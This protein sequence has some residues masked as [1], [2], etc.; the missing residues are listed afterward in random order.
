MNMKFLSRPILVAIATITGSLLVAQT[1]TGSISG[2]VA[3]STG[4]QVA[5]ATVRLINANTR[6]TKT[7]ATTASGAYIF[8]IVAAGEYVM[9][10]ESAGFKLEKRGGVTINVNQNA[11]IDFVLQVGS[12]KETVEVTADAAL[13]DTMDV[14]LGET[15]DRDRIVDLPLNGR[16]VYDLI[17]LMPGAVD[18]TTAV[19]GTNDSNNMSV[20]GNRVRNNNFYLDGGQN[21]SQWRNGG[22]MSPNPDAVAEFHLITSNFD[23]EYG[24]Q[25]GSVL[26]VVTRSGGNAYHGTIFEFLR[27]DSVN[28]QNFFHTTVIPLHWNQFGGTF[29]GPVR[30]NRTFFF[31]S[32]QGFREATSQFKNGILVP[33]VAQRAGNFSAS[34]AAKRPKDPLPTTFFQTALSRPP[35]LTRW[36]RT[37]SR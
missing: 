21:T 6:E 1:P 29:G 12:V 2:T 7:A 36:R 20:N 34:A 10:A 9:E 27:N 37:S 15:V 17:G 30:R 26:N 22:N 3:D 14:Q 19:S 13:V 18:V 28:A 35:G 32:Y 4:G 8:P 5:G 24:R 11:R 25:P 33:T 16:N 31:A 23:A